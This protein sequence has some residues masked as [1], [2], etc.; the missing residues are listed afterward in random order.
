[1]ERTI[2]GFKYK[3]QN[4]SY[5]KGL[6][7]LTSSRSVAVSHLCVSFFSKADKTSRLAIICECVNV[8]YVLVAKGLFIFM[9]KEKIYK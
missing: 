9:Y 4:R 2:L 8:A 6:A 3:S 1:M 5:G 7:P